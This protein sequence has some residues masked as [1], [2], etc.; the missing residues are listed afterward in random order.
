MGAVKWGVSVKE[1]QEGAP[2]PLGV[3]SLFLHPL[4]DKDTRTA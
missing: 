1:G 3:S 4:Q 2:K